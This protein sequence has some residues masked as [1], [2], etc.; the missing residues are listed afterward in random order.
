MQPAFLRPLAAWLADA[1]QRLVEAER[2]R[3]VPFLAVAVAGGAA[4]YF[5]L[6]GEP[7]PRMGPAM[8]ASGITLA[9]LGRRRWPVLALGLLAIAAGLGFAA[10]QWGTSR[11]PAQPVLPTRAAIVTGTVTS[12]EPLPQGRRVTLSKPRIDNG[13]ELPRALRIRLR[14]TDPIPVAAGDRLRVRAMLQPPSG[15]PLPGGWDIQFDAYH[16]GLAGYGYALNPAERL[17]APPPGGFAAWMQAL[18]ETVV[19]RIHAALPGSTGR[20][21]SGLIVGGTTGI[22]AQDQ[23]AFRDSGLFHLLSIS[24][25]HMAIVV[26][27]VFA[28]LRMGLAAI[29]W[30]ALRLP[31]KAIAA[32]LALAVGGFYT[33]LAGAEV[34]TVRSFTAACLVT[35]AILVG[36][37]AFS[38]RSWAL[39]LAAVV[40][41]APHEVMRVSLQMSFA[42]TLALIAGFE[43]LRPWLTGLAG[44]GRQLRRAGAW[45][46]ALALT[47]ALAG[48]ATAPFGA[49]HF[50]AVQLYYIVANM[51]AVPLTTILVM[52][53]AVVAMVLMPLGLERLALVPMGW[54]VEG[55]LAIGRFVAAWPQAV[56]P[57]PQITAWG[58]ATYGLGL[59]WLALWRSR[60]RLL[61]LAAIA[62]GLASAPLYRP[63]HLLVSAD[64]RLIALRAGAVLHVHR[65]QSPSSFVLDAWLRHLGLRGWRAMP[66]P[67]G[68]S[69]DGAIACG[70]TSCTLQPWPGAPS[71]L[72]LRGPAD[73]SACGHALVVS[74]EPVRLECPVATID[75][76]SVWREGAHAVWLDPAGPRILTDRAHRGDRPWVTPLPTRTRQQP[77]PPLPPAQAET[78]RRPG[79]RS[80]DQDDPIE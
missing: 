55:L 21:A 37:R 31:I 69:D 3:F 38:M 27:L 77:G 62:A 60:I 67:G 70:A 20:L 40:L 66:P 43:A 51:V 11:A 49:Y 12:V 29:E 13:P 23:A 61:G 1:A 8:V 42:A 79:P 22:P 19:A 56:L 33:L 68:V 35:L 18:R 65:T 26:G 17:A 48:T 73:G 16:T 2:G 41:V 34:P 45:I 4:Y 75:R 46:V 25:L 78:L 7:N 32:I 72:L 50:G 24:G 57:V 74:P 63:P 15:A 9:L 59:A 80:A 14:P 6:P 53:A 47:S 5:A 76:F 28:T 64:A 54:G 71:I 36:R 44:Q 39:A 58:I 10:A 30:T 52:P